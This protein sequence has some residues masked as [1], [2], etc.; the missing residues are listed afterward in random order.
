MNTHK[1][2]TPIGILLA[3]TAHAR[4]LAAVTRL[5]QL[6][7]AI[8]ECLPAPLDQHCLAANVQGKTLILITDSPA[9]SVRLRYHAPDI[10]RSLDRLLG[11]K[12]RTLR[13]KISPL[14]TPLAKGRTRRLELSQHNSELIRQTAASL[15]DPALKAAL[16]R[17]SRHS[18]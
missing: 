11:L 7:R 5:Q 9:W 8:T 2:P 15:R 13:V 10:L 1:K 12:L 3:G 16:L 6:T 4:L 17:L 18:V 14:E